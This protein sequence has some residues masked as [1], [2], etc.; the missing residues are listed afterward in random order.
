MPLVL[1]TTTGLVPIAL[2]STVTGGNL[3]LTWDNSAGFKL[4]SATTLSPAN[5]TDVP[6]ATQDNGFPPRPL[7]LDDRRS[8][9]ES[10][11]V[12]VHDLALDLPDPPAGPP[13]KIPTLESARLGPETLVVRVRGLGAHAHRP[14]CIAHRRLRVALE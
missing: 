11:Y 13:N 8:E 9:G 14:R 1:A 12:R 5:W 6:G 7:R 10:Q 4:Q 2:N 3:R